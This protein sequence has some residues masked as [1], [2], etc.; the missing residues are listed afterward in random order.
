MIDMEDI[1]IK[2]NDLLEDYMD[3][4]KDVMDDV[5]RASAN[6]G[7][8]TLRVV[9]PE[10]RPKY[11]NAWRV[12]VKRNRVTANEYTIYNRE[13]GLTHLLEDGHAIWNKPGART[14]A[15]PH[16]GPTRNFLAA[17]IVDRLAERLGV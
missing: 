11:K 6:E 9:S 12:D 16:I 13:G 14:K 2:M 17:M 4:V 1:T 5:L 8:R 3:E 7:V 15:Y 10:N